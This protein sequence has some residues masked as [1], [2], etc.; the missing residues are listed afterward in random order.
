M[1]PTYIETNSAA[2]RGSV[3]KRASFYLALLC[4]G[5]ILQPACSS[6]KTAINTQ[7]LV[8]FTSPATAPTIDQGQTVNLTVSVPDS[9]GVTWSVQNAFTNNPPVGSLSNETPTS[10]TYTAPASV[11]GKAQDLV[12][13]TSISDPTLSATLSVV[14]EPPPVIT[15]ATPTP[16][17]SCPPN[18]SIV[19]PGIGAVANVGTQY[20][21][22]FTESGG[23]PPYSWSVSAPLPAGLN[24]QGNGPTQ[25]TITGTPASSGCQQVSLQVTDAAGVSSPVKNFVILVVPAPLS[26]R[27]PNIAGAYISPDPPNGGVPYP[28]TFLSANGGLPPYS[29]TLSEGSVLPPGLSI[30][31]AG[32]L[33]GTP[34][35]QGLFQNGGLGSYSFTVVVNDT[36]TPYPAVGVANLNI[37]VNFLDST[38]HSGFENGLTVSAPYAFL[39]RGFDKDGPVLIAGNFTADGAGNI[40]GGAEDVNRSSGVQANLSI[41]SGSS[42]TI[43]SDN[44]GCLTLANSAGTTTTFQFALGAC[45]TSLN[46]QQGGCQPDSSSNPGYFTRGRL[47]EYDETPGAS[48][49]GSGIVRLQDPASFTTGLSGMYALGFSGWDSIGGRVAIAGSASASSGAFSSVAV[50]INDAGVL[51]SALT[52]GSGTFSVAS[53]GR[54]T[55]GL[56]VGSASF[57]LALYPV[58]SSEAIFASTDDLSASHPLVSGEALSSTGPFGVSSFPN[59]YLLHMA[60]VSGGAPDPNI[61]VLTFDGQGTFTGTIFEN[62]GGTLGSSALSGIYGVDAT[63]GRLIL[64]PGQNQTQFPHPV[65]AYVIPTT[66]GTAAFVVSTDASAQAGALEFQALNPPVSTFGNANLVGRYFFGMDEDLDPLS[67]L[68][69][70]TA[71]L[72]GTGS[73]AGIEDANSPGSSMFV[74]NQGFSGSYS[75]SKNGTGNF[76]GETVSVTNGQV[77]YSIDESP[78][79][80]HPVITVLEQ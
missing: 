17:T 57:D 73:Q 43:G 55:A 49:H 44:R 80:L 16:L 48:T 39:L 69:G 24:L 74:P 63:T 70:G 76:G 7:P 75:V 78:L 46:Q 31:N 38:C 61:G 72:A 47:L 53:N 33:S 14:I 41:V 34:S 12:V 51:S 5:V 28:S 56:T 66:S 79:D 37:G 64:T 2:E 11:S 59:S 77:V 30:S 15:T 71:S 19:L 68:S 23:A 9:Q 40:T 13:A 60:G 32:L 65:V 54:G 50:D 36:Q 3:I 45:S 52:G 29:W 4:I 10:A 8:Q 21:T 22:T 35:A 42:Y 1:S 18:G 67:A 6:S 62:Q 27:L 25:A 58:S 20:I 26:P